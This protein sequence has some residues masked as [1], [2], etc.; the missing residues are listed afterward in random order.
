MN[1]TGLLGLSF[2]NE[3]S[4]MI[5]QKA[6]RKIKKFSNISLGDGWIEFELLE[7][8]IS[9]V[10]R[11]YD[12]MIGCIYPTFLEDIPNQYC[13][14]IRKVSERKIIKYVY[15]TSMYEMYAKICI[16]YY[17]KIKSGELQV[18]DFEKA[19]KKIKENIVSNK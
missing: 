5:I 11:K 7:E 1:T 2:F 14:T 6:L 17:S 18:V 9:R 8:Y 10:Q 3:E 13:A 19:H 16:L 15:S 4:Q 12:I